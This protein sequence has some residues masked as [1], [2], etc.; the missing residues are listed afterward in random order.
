ML[1][2]DQ[3]KAVNKNSEHSLMSSGLSVISPLKTCAARAFP[4]CEGLFASSSLKLW[5]NGVGAFPAQAQPVILI[6]RGGVEAQGC[7]GTAVWRRPTIQL[8]GGVA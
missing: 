8:T 5:T 1:A 6:E 3:R 2:R 7:E 4:P